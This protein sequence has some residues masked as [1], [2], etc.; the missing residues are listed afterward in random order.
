MTDYTLVQERG[1]RVR[2]HR[3]D[4]WMV[5][6]ARRN[7]NPM[8]TLFGCDREPPERLLRCSCLEDKR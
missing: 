8:V 6:E 3:P 1:N 7:G 2:L 4:C 5:I